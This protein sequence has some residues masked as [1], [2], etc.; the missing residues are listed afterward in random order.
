MQFYIMCFSVEVKDRRTREYFYSQ[1]L[2]PT[3]SKYKTKYVF[4]SCQNIEHSDDLLNKF[5]A[6]SA[7]IYIIRV[8][9]ELKLNM[10]VS[11]PFAL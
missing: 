2:D 5:V 3:I 8:F 11:I 4:G 7:L 10:K 1:F 6:L 9:E